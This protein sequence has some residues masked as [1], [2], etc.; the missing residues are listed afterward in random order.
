[1]YKN[2]ASIPIKKA[3]T[4]TTTTKRCT[5]NQF[6]GG[7]TVTKLPFLSLRRGSGIGFQRDIV[8]QT[9]EAD[10]YNNGAL[11]EQFPTLTKPTILRIETHKP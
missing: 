3:T 8:N 6:V 10:P 1:M 9:T 4:T 7:L 11:R 5:T 2:K